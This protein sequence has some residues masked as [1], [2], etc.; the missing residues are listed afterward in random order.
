MT[1]DQVV[2][3]PFRIG[4]KGRVV[5]PAPVREAA[6]LTEGSTLVARVEAPGRIVLEAPRAIRDLV[7]AGAPEVAV[8]PVADVRAMRADDAA[9][10]DRAAEARRS[11]QTAPDTGATLLERLGL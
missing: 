6:G 2:S 11:A 3:S 1:S 10:A 7:W 9:A 8:D 5:I 4:A